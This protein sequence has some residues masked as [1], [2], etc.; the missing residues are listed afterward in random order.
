MLTHK[1]GSGPQ[2]LARVQVLLT[3]PDGIEPSRM[4]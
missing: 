1:T 2:E 4:V 3:P